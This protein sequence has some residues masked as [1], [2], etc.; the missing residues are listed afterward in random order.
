MAKKYQEGFVKKYTGE[1]SH[2]VLG[3]P[4]YINAESFYNEFGHT[5]RPLDLVTLSKWNSKEDWTRWLESEKR[6]NI[7]KKFKEYLEKET[8]EILYKICYEVP[9]L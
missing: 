5:I 9:L 4:G 6:R 3:F 1:L 7:N 8:H 2:S